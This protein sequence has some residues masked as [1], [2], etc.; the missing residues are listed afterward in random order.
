[1]TQLDCTV[2]SCMYNKDNYCSKGDITIGGKNASNSGDTCCESFRERKSGSAMNSTGHPSST[3]DVDCEAE[4]CRYN[5]GC[6]C[7][8]GHIGIAGGQACQCEE[9]ECASFTCR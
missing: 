1:M 6:K 9:T 2:S 8:A 5:E 3:I 7:H 4:K